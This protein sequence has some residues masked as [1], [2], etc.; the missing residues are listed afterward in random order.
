MP[1]RSP[2]RWPR[3]TRSRRTPSRRWRDAR[4]AIRCFC[5]SSS[6]PLSTALPTSCRSR[7]R[8]CSRPESTRSSRPIGCCCA[9]HRS[10]GRRSSSAC[11]TRS[12]PT[13]LRAQATRA[14]GTGSASS[15]CRSDE[16]SFAFR[17]DLMRA[18]AYEGLSFRRRREIHGRVGQVLELRAG[19]RADEEAALLSL[20]FAQAGDHERGWRYAVTAGRRA[21]E[22]FA[23]IVA[24]ELFERALAAADALDDARCG[25]GRGGGSGGSRRRLRALRRLQPRRRRLRAGAAT[26]PGRPCCRDT[27]VREARR[28]RRARRRLRRSLHDL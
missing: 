7:S 17:H 28:A 26:P 2:S 16:G 5:A 3:S 1:R 23:N 13:R 20:H 4:P 19:E 18:T 8:P 27:A 10:S 11:S 25:G 15:S 21:K 9:T 14:A 6:S 12:W 22:G 24:A